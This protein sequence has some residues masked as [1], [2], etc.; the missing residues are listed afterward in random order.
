MTAP[1]PRLDDRA[2]LDPRQPL[3]SI[4]D[5]RVSFAAG[6]F[7][8]LPAVDGLSLDLPRAGAL[9]LVGESGSGKTVGTRGAI[10]LLPPSARVAGEALFDGRDLISM[11]E[12]QLRSLRG[13]RIGMVFQNAMEAFNPTLTLKRQLTEHLLWHKL[14]RRKDALRWAVE[15]MDRVGIPEPDK[16]IRMYPF[17]FSGGMLQRAMIAMAIVTRPALLIA[18]EP[19]TAL[20]VTVQRQVLDLLKDLRRDGLA[21]LM[22]TH[23]LGV[24][25]YTCDDI[26]VL[27]HGRV[28]ETGR[29]ATFGEE[30]T[31]PYSRHLIASAIDLDTRAGSG[32]ETV[33]PVTDGADS[34]AAPTRLIA[35]SRLNKIFP[36]S[37]GDVPAV[38]DVDLEIGQ[39]EAVAVVGQSGSGKST[40][41]R[42]LMGLID[43]TS[44]TVS[45]RGRD[46]HSAGSSTMR[47]FRR[48]VQMVFQNP[49]GSLLPHLSVVANVAEPLRLHRVAGSRGRTERARELLDLVGIPADL[50][51]H[52]PR[53]LSGGQQQRVAIARALALDPA[54]LVCDEPTSALDV[55]IQAEILDLLSGL[56]ER[57]GLSLLFVTHNLAV[58]Q[59]L[60]DRIVVM[61]DGLIVEMAPTEE[62][63]TRP[64]HP[65]TKALLSAVMPTHG[66]P[67]P[68]VRRPATIG[69]GALIE[70]NSDHWV[71]QDLEDR[72][73]PTAGR[74]PARSAR[75]Q[76]D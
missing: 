22:I 40:L 35:A 51:E 43:A 23:D 50:Q 64:G 68:L 53:Q 63:F 59:R 38:I 19:T 71:R 31:E 66:D 44:G 13:R 16:R 76:E 33:P 57:L 73:Q 37:G 11:P 27:R 9:A 28:V 24:A 60:C 52:Y 75:V 20:D 62:L 7:D 45:Y 1:V 69:R 10:G 25:R 2:D 14:C 58:A 49:Y 12:E 15:A 29:M 46:L 70:I 34:P 18:D 41:A 61:A 32:V 5:L 42:L 30:A 55:S 17:Q 56:R 65:Y 72:H 67:L 21:M 39:D 26:V 3:L 74:D 8:D 47:Q 48:S 54:V 4:R 36:T 6:R